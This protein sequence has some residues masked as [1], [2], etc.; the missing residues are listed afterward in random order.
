LAEEIENAEKREKEERENA[1]KRRTNDVARASVPRDVPMQPEEKPE[2]VE[3]SQNPDGPGQ[4]SSEHMHQTGIQN[5]SID[6]P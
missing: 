1:G 3:G 2:A 5:E 6:D 4:S